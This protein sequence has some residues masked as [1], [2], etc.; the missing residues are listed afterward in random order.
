MCVGTSGGNAIIEKGL[1]IEIRIDF[2]VSLLNQQLNQEVYEAFEEC[3]FD[4]SNLLSRVMEFD[5]VTWIK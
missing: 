5:R 4:Q 3:I 1:T 2:P